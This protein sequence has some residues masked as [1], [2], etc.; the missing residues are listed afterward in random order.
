MCS[1]KKRVQNILSEGSVFVEVCPRAVPLLAQFFSIISRITGTEIQPNLQKYSH[2]NVTELNLLNHV[3]FIHI[4]LN[5]IS[6]LGKLHGLNLN[7]WL[8]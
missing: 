7:N 3:I 4:V 1:K 6:V 8:R 2:K 5:M